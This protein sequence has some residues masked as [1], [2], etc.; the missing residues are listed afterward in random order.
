MKDIFK[1]LIQD[2]IETIINQFHRKPHNF[3]NEHEFHQYCYHVFY[4]KKEFSRQY[5]TKDKDGKRTNILHPEYPTLKRFNRKKLKVNQGVR[6]RYD[7]AIL[8]PKFIENN[9]FK[10]V[11]CRNIKLFK[12]PKDFKSKNLI[13]ALEFKFIIR[14]SLQYEHEIKYD[15]FK[16]SNAEEVELKYMLVFT[17]T[18]EGEK[19]EGENYFKSLKGNKEIKIIYVAVFMEEGKKKKRVKQYPDYWLNI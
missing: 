7:M 13:A 9:S 3:F 19:E 10:K 11:Q 14:H 1:T 2:S 4:G 15:H 16:L 8:N 6:A 5:A 18:I 17:N 12:D